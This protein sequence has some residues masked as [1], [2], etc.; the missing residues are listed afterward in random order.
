MK[1][2]DGIKFGIGYMVA[3]VLFYAVTGHFE[4]KAANDDEYMNGLKDRKPDLYNSLLK[5]RKN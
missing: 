5:Y 3:Q 2:R 4:R 1:I